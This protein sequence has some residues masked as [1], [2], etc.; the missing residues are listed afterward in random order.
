M[1]DLLKISDKVRNGSGKVRFPGPTDNTITAATSYSSAH[2]LETLLLK[3][4]FNH[5]KAY[6]EAFPEAPLEDEVFWALKNGCIVDGLPGIVLYA[7]DLLW[8]RYH[9]PNLLLQKSTK[10]VLDAV[11]D[12]SVRAYDVIHSFYC[13]EY[14][15]FEPHRLKCWMGSHGEIYL[16]KYSRVLLLPDSIFYAID[17]DDS[18]YISYDGNQIKIGDT[19]IWSI[20]GNEGAAY[21]ACDLRCV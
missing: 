14:E 4:M 7:F 5:P 1:L 2:G 12:S 17:E 8:D 3:Q 18:P 10:E 15:P 9:S 13:A 11:F 16:P 20:A 19:P 21:D 6:N